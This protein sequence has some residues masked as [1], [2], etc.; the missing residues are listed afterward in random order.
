[1]RSYYFELYAELEICTGTY[2]SSTS[3]SSPPRSPGYTH[4]L[5]I[6]PCLDVNE[7]GPRRT[8]VHVL[9]LNVEQAF[10]FFTLGALARRIY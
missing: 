1:M 7:T 2:K 10:P 3:W 4:A 9:R 8:R 6:L 5:I